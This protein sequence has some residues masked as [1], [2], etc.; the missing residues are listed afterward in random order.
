MVHIF[1]STGMMIKDD[2][3]GNVEESNMFEEWCMS[4]LEGIVV[5]LKKRY[6]GL[7]LMIFY[8]TS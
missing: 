5:E 1:D 4:C 3:D 2:Y 7:T 8:R 6:P